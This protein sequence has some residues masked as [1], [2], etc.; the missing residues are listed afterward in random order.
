MP[1]EDALLMSPAQQ[2][3]W[4]D[5]A[6]MN[7]KVFSQRSHV[8]AAQLCGYENGSLALRPDRIR[9][10]GRWLCNRNKAKPGCPS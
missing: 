6:H 10:A 2:Q 1:T 3:E 9:R 5:L 8:S 7:F 4:R